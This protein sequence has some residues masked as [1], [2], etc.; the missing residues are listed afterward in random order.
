VTDGLDPSS[1]AARLHRLLLLAYPA[2]FRRRFGTG[3]SYAF[4]L[5]EAAARNAG[6]PAWF[7]FWL[8]TIVDA[9]RCGLAERCRFTSRPLP[10][11][12]MEVSMGS[13]FTTDWRDGWRSL[14]ATPLVTAI[15]VLSLA[16]GIGANTALF[17][18][19]NTLI[20]KPLPVREPDRL[21][22]I[23]HDS[24]TNPIWEAL[25]DRHSEFAGDAVAWGGTRLDFGSGADVQAVS[26][27][28]V[29]GGFFAGLG[30]GAARGRTIVDRDDDRRGSSDAAVAVLSHRFWQ[31][32]FGGSE[33]IIGR[34][35]TIGRVPFTIVGVTP[36]GFLG[37]DVGASFDVALPIAS[38]RLL[39]GAESDLDRRD[40]WWLSLMF[41]LRPG[42]TID[43]ATARLRAIQPQVR[44]ETL[45]AHWRQSDQDGYLREP[46]TLVAAGA[47]RSALR[48]RYERP[49]GAIMVVVALVL[50]IACANIANLLLARAVARR[51]ELSVRLALGASRFRL[52]RQ[53]LAESLM[54]TLAGTAIGVIFARWGGQALVARLTTLDS[55][56]TLD[57]SLDWRV[58][59]FTV[60][61]AGTTA[62]LFGLA[63]ALGVSSL[64]PNGA[65]REHDRGTTGDRRLGFR[66][67]LVVAQVALSLALL[68]AAGL[69][70]TTLGAL[71]TRDVG[72]DRRSVL[73][74]HVDL[75]SA[76]I[77][78]DQ[79]T[80][81]FER[82]RESAASVSG[83]LQAAASFTTPVSRRGWNTAIKLPGSTL[84]PRQRLSWVN[85]VSPGW[86]E[87]FGVRLIAGRE[88]DARDGAGA[89]R[90]A[91]VNRAFAAR[92]IKEE[93]PV[94]VTFTQEGDQSFEIVAVVADT[95]YRSLR[96][97][98][99]PSMFIPVAQWKGA[100][101]E[102]TL[103]VRTSGQDP[104]AM[105]K[106][107]TN[108]VRGQAPE[109]TLAF[110]SLE[111]QVQSSLTQERL[112]A[113]LSS[114][115][116]AL[117][118]VLAGLGLYG[119]TSYAVSRRRTEIGI[120]MALGA[121]PSG[122]VTLVLSRVAWL[123]GIGIIAGTGLSLWAGRFIGSLLYSVQPTDPATFVAAALV[124]G[125]V[126]FIAGWLPA[127]RASRVDP[128]VVLREG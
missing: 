79:R 123:V 103:A 64:A 37:P 3:L 125:L 85:A 65:L 16:L 44:L 24:W 83:A 128:T 116:G 117:A 58:L 101:A 74:A 82:L 78:P 127:R 99:S 51:H 27:L 91:I 61:V 56:V 35:V 77:A 63:P 30:I 4:A 15:A 115:F 20:F 96:S 36:Q 93:N 95:V 109:A 86:F 67:A 46:L 6:L 13:M 81:V 11:A 90:V 41:R 92:Y 34:A 106:A 54:L 80:A 38:E 52:S 68:V 88:F 18:I 126:A 113:M 33:D 32:R 2:A 114:F 110:H 48:T 120:R 22:A 57:L 121:E 107:V 50:L 12:P 122:V 10:H 73:V 124:L 45:P 98:M 53:L 29:S 89:A 9:L 40:V 84:G 70:M 87:T 94:G 104:M 75:Q 105:V 42:Q 1:R 111:E 100:P 59:G 7:F 8:V 17:S 49:L 76:G 39:R 26:G 108:A 19:L 102:V 55:A 118:L 69:F 66:N 112:V 119:V 47:G 14:S 5:D 25:R 97:E 31:R 62:L 21:V 72:F 71:T 28:Y 23:E 60:L 43:D